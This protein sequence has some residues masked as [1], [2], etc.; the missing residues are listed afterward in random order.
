[1]KPTKDRNPSAVFLDYKGEGLL[2]DCGEGTQRQFFRAS[3][4][5]T[6]VTRIFISHWHGDHV[7]GLAGLLSTLGTSDYDGEVHVYGPSG[8]T[9]R[10][11]LWMRAIAFD[12]GVNMKVHEVTKGGVILDTDDFFV[13]AYSLKHRIACLGFAFQEKDRRRMNVT[14]LKTAGVPQGPLW[15]KLQDGQAVQVKGKTI[16]P[17][18]VTTIVK[19]KRVAYITDT[20]PHENCYKL[21]KDADVLICEAPHS[22]DIQ[23]K[24]E[25]YMHLTAEQA[26]KIAS[27]SG[28][29][30][31]VLQH[32]SSRYPDTKELEAD[33]K[34]VFANV[35]CASDFLGMTV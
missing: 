32:F 8:T 12:H 20:L 19:G 15:G 28:V 34:K 30:K 27:E 35:V 21:A 33:A 17:D 2:F 7:L 9:E 31:L 5:V 13:E 10:L 16:M 22:S 3:M 14:A 6:A 18:S 23:D 1:M 25:E 29:K 11:G 26:G 24:A 4:K